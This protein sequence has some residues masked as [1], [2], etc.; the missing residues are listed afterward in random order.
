[1]SIYRDGY[2]AALRDAANIAARHVG[3]AAAERQRRGKPFDDEVQAEE[4][5]EDIAAALIEKV[6]RA[7]ATHQAAQ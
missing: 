3:S 1:M 2:I 4:R 5:G 6:I 7:L